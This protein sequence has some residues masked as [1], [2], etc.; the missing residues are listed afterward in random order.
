MRALLLESGLWT[1]LRARP[2]SKVPS[3]ETKPHALY[4]T[5]I[6]TR[7]HAPAVATALAGHETDFSVGVACLSR[8]TDGATF[9]CLAPGHQL[10][11]P[12]LPTVRTCLLYTSRC[13]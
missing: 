11:V 3:P 13:V 9:V 10:P 2:F 4:I 6:D 12:T 8:L 5:A 7:P 1:A